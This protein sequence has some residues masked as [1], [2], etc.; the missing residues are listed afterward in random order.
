MV[1]KL[2]ERL[3][4][5]SDYIEIGESMA[6]IGTDHGFLPIYLWEEKRSPKVILS[7]IGQGPLEKA[8]ENLERV[9][10]IRVLENL[11]RFFEHKF[12]NSYKSYLMYGSFSL[13]PLSP[14]TNSFSGFYIRKGSGISTL[15]PGEV[16]VVVIA[17]M[18]GLLIQSILEEEL[19]KAKSYSKLILQPRN[20]PEKLKIWLEVK[21]FF[22]NDVRLVKERGRIWE[23]LLVNP[24]EALTN[25]ERKGKLFSKK[26]E[27]VEKID[28]FFKT[29]K[30]DLIS[31]EMEEILFLK[32]D[33]L[34]VSWV[35]SK[36][37]KEREILQSLALGERNLPS[38][39]VGD[40]LDEKEQQGLRRLNIKRQHELRFDLLQELKA[41]SVM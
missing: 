35:E 28:K 5:I 34:L 6:D 37:E 25:E 13:E 24:F 12:D 22:I 18:G 8:A 2:S 10:G 26:P 41:I 31:R 7:D 40:S 19:E 3:Q 14:T 20:A 11:K 23:I 38:I 21:G 36:I 9:Y 4:V 17:G 33:P 30:E 15:T 16:D 1:I 29:H 32:E 39:G 27:K